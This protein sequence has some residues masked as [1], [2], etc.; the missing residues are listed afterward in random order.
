MRTKTAIAAKPIDARGELYQ[1]RAF[2]ALPLLARQALAGN[3]IYYGD[4]ARELAMP[5]ERNL[6]YVLGAVGTSLKQLGKEWS[7]VIPPL[8]AVVVNR[9]S[10]LPGE[11]F[12][13]FVP[14][15]M[16]FRAAPTHR[17]KQIIGALLAQVYSYPRWTA[18]LRHLGTGPAPP[19]NLEKKLPRQVR[20][21]LAGGGESDAHKAFKEFIASRP[22]LIGLKIPVEK[23]E[24]EYLF[25]SSDAVD[26]LFCAARLRIAVEVKSRVSPYEDVLRGLFQCVK[27]DALL[28]ATLALEASEASSRVVL[29]LEG[30]F[31]EDLRSV[32]N[33][34]GVEVLDQLG[35]AM[36]GAV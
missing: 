13:E 32:A 34:L 19:L 28:R 14:D 17:K 24:L 6:N 35:F 25:P 36:R 11:G 4:L 15:S 10:G 3:T 7:E 1:Q 18:V 33:T 8:Q 12:A 27:Y 26:V 9:H 2:R 23:A 30:K 22:D 31:P 16:A 21:S 29:A 20:A 5:N